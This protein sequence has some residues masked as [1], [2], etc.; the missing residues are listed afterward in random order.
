MLETETKYF[1]K[2]FS[3]LVSNS[4]GQYVLI[5]NEEVIGVFEAISDALKIGYEKYKEDSF[6]VKLIMPFQQPVNFT[7][8][9]YF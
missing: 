2:I 6:F 3:E 7:H 9:S 8:N 1:E 4:K 5:K